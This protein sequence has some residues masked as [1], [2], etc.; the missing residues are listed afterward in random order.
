MYLPV[1]G[2]PAVLLDSTIGDEDSDRQEC[3]WQLLV[4][5]EFHGDKEDW[6]QDLKISLQQMELQELTQSAQFS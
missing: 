5:S 3:A 2:V 1:P 4:E 6:D